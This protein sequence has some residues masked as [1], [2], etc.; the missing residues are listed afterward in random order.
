MLGGRCMQP[1]DSSP[2]K[3]VKRREP[4]ERPGRKKW[5][6]SVEVVFMEDPRDLP[7]VGSKTR[8]AEAG[9]S[10]ARPRRDAGRAKKISLGSSKPCAFG[11][12][13]I[14]CAFCRFSVVMPI[15]ILKSI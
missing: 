4:W 2:R 5:E 12:R 3:P 1:E 9:G 13:L 11:F 6:D 15:P 10:K 7:R 14:N 8:M